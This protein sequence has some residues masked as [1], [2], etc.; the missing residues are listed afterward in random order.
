MSS[1]YFLPCS[2][3]YSVQEQTNTTHIKYAQLH[4]HPNIHSPPLPGPQTDQN[5]DILCVFLVWFYP[6]PCPLPMSLLY[7]VSST[8][9]LAKKLPRILCATS[10]LRRFLAVKHLEQIP[11]RPNEFS[12]TLVSIFEQISGNFFLQKWIY[13]RQLWWNSIHL[14]VKHELVFLG[15]HGKDFKCE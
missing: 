13:R 12:D 15:L 3:C 5:T 10:F 2:I 11:V 7:R 8:P 4:T 1:V 14:L 9:L 6:L